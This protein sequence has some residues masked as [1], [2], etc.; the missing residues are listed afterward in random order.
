[1]HSTVFATC[2]GDG[3]IDVWGLDNFEEPRL[4]FKAQGKVLGLLSYGMGVLYKDGFCF[5]M[6]HF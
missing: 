3:Y 5:Y 1:M 2:D 4:H 6:N